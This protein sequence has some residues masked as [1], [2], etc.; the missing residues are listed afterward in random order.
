MDGTNKIV[1][2][3]YC[4]PR[5]ILENEFDPRYLISGQSNPYSEAWCKTILPKKSVVP[6]KRKLTD[7]FFTGAVDSTA[8]YTFALSA[9]VCALFS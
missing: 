6:G 9:L 2:D 8:V 3:R 7:L 5:T 4:Y 1:L